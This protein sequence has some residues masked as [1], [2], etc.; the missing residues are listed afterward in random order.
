MRQ[1]TTNDH[2]I[3]LMSLFYK[4]EIDREKAI[5]KNTQLLHAI[6]YTS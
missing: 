6:D 5:V 2:L 4:L 3:Y 1:K